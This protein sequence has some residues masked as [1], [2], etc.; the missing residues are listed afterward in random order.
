MLWCKAKHFY[1]VQLEFVNISQEWVNCFL[2]Y[3]LHGRPQS[4]KSSISN[5]R[6]RIIHLL[7][8]EKRDNVLEQQ[9]S[10]PIDTS[11][12]MFQKAFQCVDWWGS[13]TLRNAAQKGF[14]TLFGNVLRVQWRK[15]LARNSEACCLM[16]GF[17][18]SITPRTSSLMFWKV[19]CNPIAIFQ[20][21]NNWSN[22]KS[23]V[24]W[25][26]VFWILTVRKT[27]S[28]ASCKAWTTWGFFSLNFSK[29]VGTTFKRKHFKLLSIYFSVDLILRYC[30][31]LLDL[32]MS[33]TSSSILLPDKPSIW[34]PW[35]LAS[36]WHLSQ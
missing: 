21:I 34:L 8:R 31:H 26:H 6:R 19:V 17:L 7:Y 12:D 9:I 13:C 33:Q 18:L 36:H 3:Y 25:H 14:R 10:R 23:F 11:T 30:E 35:P 20:V 28:M 5:L 1:L 27:A 29:M 24:N 32:H 15:L 22:F 2:P 16:D 4:L